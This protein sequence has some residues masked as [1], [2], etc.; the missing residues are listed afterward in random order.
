MF[1]N[2]GRNLRNAGNRISERDYASRIG[3]AL[4]GEL[5]GS[6]RATKTIMAWTGSS[7]RTARNWV[8]AIGGPSGR[9]LISLMGQSDAV[10][11]MVLELSGRTEL[12]VR[13]DIHAVEVALAKATGALEILKRQSSP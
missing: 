4:H 6:A 12:L 1:P 10:L 7:D 2:N 8:H 5:G 9:H 13:T 11:T 3:A